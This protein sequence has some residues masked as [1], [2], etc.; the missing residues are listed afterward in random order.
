MTKSVSNVELFLAMCG[1]SSV[2]EHNLAKVGVA[3][4][5][6]VSRSKFPE[7]MRQMLNIRASLQSIDSSVVNFL[8][9]AQ[10]RRRSQVVRQSSAKALFISSILIAASN[11]FNNFT[12]L[13]EYFAGKKLVKSVCTPYQLSSKLTTLAK[14]ISVYFKPHSEHCFYSFRLADRPT[15][16]KQCLCVSTSIVRPKT[17]KFLEPSTQNITHFLP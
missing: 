12:R 16:V 9:S 8:S 7:A 11:L 4:S 15:T 1:N 5:N 13:F 14:L 10:H 6:L 3:S 2:V 17:P